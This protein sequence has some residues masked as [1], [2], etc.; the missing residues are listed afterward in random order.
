MKEKQKDILQD[1]RLDKPLSKEAAR[2]RYD[3][4]SIEDQ[5]EDAVQFESLAEVKIKKA[6]TDGVFDDLPGK[7][8]PIDLNN[9]CS[10]PEHLRMGY[11]M[12]KNSGYLPE[13]VRLKKEMEIIKEEIQQCASEAEKQKLMKRLSETSQQFNFYMEYNMKFRKSLF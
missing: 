1:P 13:E 3:R 5:T 12:L 10:M 2:T 6:M 7:G 4:S 9:Y 11:Q 8:R